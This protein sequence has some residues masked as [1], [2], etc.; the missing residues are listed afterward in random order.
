MKNATNK[1]QSPLSVEHWKEIEQED[2]QNFYG[3]AMHFFK[4]NNLL[5]I[6]EVLQS[7]KVYA[8]AD[9]AK[10]DRASEGLKSI[11]VRYSAHTQDLD[12]IADKRLQHV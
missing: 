9:Q 6:I 2:R 8:S 11:W 10:I 3:C 4:I 12:K 5:E 7:T 1:L